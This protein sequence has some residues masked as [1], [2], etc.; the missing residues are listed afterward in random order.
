MRNKKLMICAAL[1]L[2]CFCGNS[3]ITKAQICT[4]SAITV[5]QNTM[6]ASDSLNSTM[7]AI[8]LPEM[9]DTDCLY[10]AT[11]NVLEDTD[12]G[13]LI[14]VLS[15]MY[16]KSDVRIRSQKSTDSKIVDVLKF[17]KSIT[18]LNYDPQKSW[19]EIEYKGKIRYICTDYLTKHKPKTI[20]I[21]NIKLHGL[22]TDQ[23]QRAYTIAKVC[24]KEWKNY[25]VLPSVAIAQ[26]MQESTL[27]KRCYGNNLWGILTKK[28]T[29]V[30]YSSFENGIYGY[31][32]TINNGHYGSAPFTKN[33]SSQISKIL[34]GG[35]CSPINKY[36]NDVMWIINK[37]DLERFDQMI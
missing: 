4:G 32:H 12:S 11:A 16:A 33:A 1:M 34:A 29:L 31:L 5:S 18:V 21:T 15:K 20:N 25:G 9:F 2:V 3:Q 36:Y 35:Y 27:G 17:G 14:H 6:D 19:Q 10:E 26:A 37:Y 24:I 8:S 13:I 28:R 22:S 7:S 30:C 23:Q